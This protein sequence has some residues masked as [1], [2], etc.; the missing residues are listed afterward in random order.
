MHRHKLALLL[1]GAIVAGCG[2]TF[3]ITAAVTP[4][5]PRIASAAAEL[6]GQQRLLAGYPAQRLGFI[7]PLHRTHLDAPELAESGC[8]AC[9]LETPGNRVSHRLRHRCLD[10]HHDSYTPIHRELEDDAAHDC[11]SCHDFLHVGT[12]VRAATACAV[13]H[14]DPDGVKPRWAADASRIEVHADEECERCHRPHQRPA[15][16]A[17]DCLEC[18]EEETTEHRMGTQDAGRC[19]DCHRV[20][21]A[22]GEAEGR[23][24]SCHQRDVP[25]T[26]IAAHGHEQCITCHPSHGFSRATTATCQSCHPDL[27]VL[28]AR[29]K[30]HSACT[31]CHPDHDTV[32]NERQS[33]LRCHAETAPGHSAADDGSRCVNCHPP[34]GAA[35][36]K[37]ATVACASCH[38][39]V[40]RDD[41]LHGGVTCVDCHPTHRFDD[42][43]ASPEMCLGCHA[44]S[45]GTVRRVRVCDGH[46]SCADCHDDAA[47]EPEAAPPACKSCHADQDRLATKG[48]EKCADCHDAHSGRIGAR[49]GCS[50]C[51]AEETVGT[52]RTIDGGCATCHR[53]HG[54]NGPAQPPACVSCHP[55]G[56]LSGD[57]R[58]VARQKC[59]DCHRVHETHARRGFRGEKK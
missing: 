45:V 17:R 7:N 28:A 19:R 21:E 29:V 52:H 46:E 16:L 57:H 3:A 2:V 15:L 10:C 43:E 38:D 4:A 12:A 34:H 35:I 22:I 13:C 6:P 48:H 1:G 24:R 42:V 49:A 54:P 50:S 31:D 59:E 56:E 27:P 20:H 25:A 18:H 58:S 9:H 5:E 14:T 30:G 40:D 11:L 33:C 39:E 37:T 23:C 36:R 55:V 47:H 51:H 8:S 26:A 41:E 32:Q 44:K 53:A